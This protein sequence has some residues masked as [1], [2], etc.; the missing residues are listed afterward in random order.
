MENPTLKKLPAYFFKKVWGYDPETWPVLGFGKPAGA[1]QL[2]REYSTGDWVVLVGTKSEPTHEEDRGRLLGLVQVTNRIIEV[3]PLLKELK[4]ELGDNAYLNGK[5]KWPQGFPY[6]NAWAFRDKPLIDD[7]FPGRNRT[8][9]R[10]EAAFAMKLN[11]EEAKVIAALPTE[12]TNFVLS[13]L[14][15]SYSKFQDVL[16]RPGPPP[17]V[18]VREAHYEDGENWVYI[19]RIEGTDFYKIGR[20]NDVDRRLKEFNSSPHAIWSGKP[21]VKV[22]SHEFSSAGDAHDIEQMVLDH[23]KDYRVNGECFN[24]RK[25]GIALIALANMIYE[26]CH[27][28]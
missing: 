25:E 28:A 21:L 27:P 10:V 15:E 6:L 14:L 22:T 2:R 16:T 18:G 17:A 11:D 9:G 23:L 1:D 13:P 24:I 12:E 8:R 7:L 3:E 20:A 26:F 5:F 4:T 19:F